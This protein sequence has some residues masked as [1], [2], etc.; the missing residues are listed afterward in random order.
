MSTFT[1]N[2]IQL[3]VHTSAF[4]TGFCRLSLERT[5]HSE[6]DFDLPTTGRAQVRPEGRRAGDRARGPPGRVG[7]VLQLQG[8]RDRLDLPGL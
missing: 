5:D 3:R 1:G 2:T 8:G 7:P 6:Q 4:Y